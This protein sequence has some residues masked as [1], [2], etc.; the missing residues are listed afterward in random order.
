MVVRVGNSYIKLHFVGMALEI[1]FQKISVL[2]KGL[3]AN[4]HT[5]LK[6][7]W[8]YLNRHHVYFELPE[9]LTYQYVTSQSFQ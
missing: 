5:K 2:S 4:N 9:L 7:V 3:V 1:F 6:K 8:H